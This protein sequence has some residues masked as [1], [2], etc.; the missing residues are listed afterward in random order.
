MNINR[1]IRRI[2]DKITLQRQKSP[3]LHIFQPYYGDELVALDIET[4]SL[5]TKKAEIVS[6]GA[7]KIK[8][9]QVKTSQKLDVR[10]CS[11][12]HLSSD[13]IK[14]HMLRHVDLANGLP[15]GEALD[16]LLQFIGNRPLVGYYIRYDLTVLNK[17]MRS[18]YAFSLPNN[19]TDI[20][21]LYR[22]KLAAK[23]VNESDMLL[24]F[25]TIAE[26][27][28]VP[29][30]GRHTALGDAITTALMFV[31]MQANEK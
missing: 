13:S 18:K 28:K 1:Q 11:P 25:D 23:G 19:A 5:D 14:V 4:T 29:I 9:N 3:W 21:D 6:I 26:Q 22:Q 20:T 16:A 8:S 30:V 2:R 24:S 15:V 7:V 27:L 10:I 31:K 17:L 12:K